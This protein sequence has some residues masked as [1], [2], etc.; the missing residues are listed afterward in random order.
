MLYHSV[1]QILMCVQITWISC[2]EDSD[3]VDTA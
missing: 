2:T 3:L 1:S